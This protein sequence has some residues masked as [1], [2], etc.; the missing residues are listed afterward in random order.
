MKEDKQEICDLLCKAL[1]A[2]RYYKGELN[3]LRYDADEERVFAVFNN[4]EQGINVELDSGIAMIRDV[5]YN[6]E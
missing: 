5:V 2:T 4:Y 3:E 1:Q 6:I